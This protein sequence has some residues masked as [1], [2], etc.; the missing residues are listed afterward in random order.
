MPRYFFHEQGAA[1]RADEERTE[2]HDL[3]SAR[4]AALKLLARIVADDPDEF[5]ANKEWKLIVEDETR[6]TLFE[7]LIIATESAA[8][9]SA[10]RV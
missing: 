3:E 4:I 1:R 6:L 7:L 10:R 9:S 8:G 5:W 2:L